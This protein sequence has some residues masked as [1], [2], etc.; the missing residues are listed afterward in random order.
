MD[1]ALAADLLEARQF[2]ERVRIVEPY[3]AE[4]PREF[5]GTGATLINIDT[6]LETCG[7]LVVL[8]DHDVFRV[9]PAEERRHAVVYDTRGIWPEAA[10]A[11]PAN[12]IRL[13]S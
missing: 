2:G 7:V 11:Q 5:N 4:L 9:V 10:H 1:E 13:A 8:V 3:A 12:K 6:A